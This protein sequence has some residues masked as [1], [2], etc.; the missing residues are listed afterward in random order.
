MLESSITQ[1]QARRSCIGSQVE[2]Q[3]CRQASLS[4]VVVKRNAA[5]PHAPAHNFRHPSQAACH[6]QP[7]S[8]K[9]DLPFLLIFWGVGVLAQRL[10]ASWCRARRLAAPVR[11]EVMGPASQSRC[12]VGVPLY[13][14][15]RSASAVVPL[16]NKLTGG[17]AARDGACVWS[18]GDFACRV[19][20]LV[21]A[22]R[23]SASTAQVRYSCRANEFIRCPDQDGLPGGNS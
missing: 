7:C 5:A 17:V 23:W 20:C 15:Y 1:I 12:A 8:H 11:S 10:L 2:H 9:P 19:V 13:G 14:A 21:I 6:S 18:H 3:C 16:T 4:Q 22:T